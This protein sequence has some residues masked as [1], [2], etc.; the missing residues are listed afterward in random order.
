MAKRVTF[1]VQAST[2]ASAAEVYRLLRDGATWPTWSPLGSFRLER[3]GREGG[4][5]DGAIRVFRTGTVRSREELVDLCP[6]RSLSYIAL[7]GLPLRAHRADVE[8]TAHDDGTTITWREAFE[9]KIPGTGR[10]LRMFLRRF[11]QRSADGLA[12]YA[13]TASQ[14]PR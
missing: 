11:I 13:P 8:L 3:E 14:V 12:S 5:S 10:F 7:S 1:A 9:P 4:E 6:D 2:R